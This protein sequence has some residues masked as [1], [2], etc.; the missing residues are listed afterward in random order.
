MRVIPLYKDSIIG[1]TNGAISLP[2]QGY[3]ID[4]TGT[5]GEANRKIRVFKGWPQT[6]L[7]YLSYG[8][9]VAKDN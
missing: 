8:L 7:P 1:M 5:S 3:K 4:S 2:L 9:F 6:Y